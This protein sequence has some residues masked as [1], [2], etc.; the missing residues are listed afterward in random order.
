MQIAFAF[1]YPKTL[2]AVAFFLRKSNSGIDKAKLMKLIYLADRASFIDRGLP[3]TG[4][5]PYAMKLGPVPSN[6]LNMIDGEFS[7]V[8]GG[9]YEHI[10]LMNVNVSLAKDPGEELLSNEEKESLEAIWKQHGHKKT[11]PLCYETHNLPEYRETFVE[12]TSTR[13]PYEVI[14]RHSGNPARYRKGRPVISPEMAEMIKPPFP[15]EKNLHR[16]S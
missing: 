2:Q 4:D 7:P 11:I 6:T 9:V 10:T 13:I 8:Y 15:P 12:G 14:A 3:I 5:S 16:S 1:D